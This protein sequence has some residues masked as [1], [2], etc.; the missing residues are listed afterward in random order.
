ME[1]IAGQSFRNFECILINNNSTDKSTIIAQEFVKT[2]PRFHLIHEKKQGVVFASNSGFKVSKGKYI[3]RMD[4]DD[5][6]FPGRLEK[7]FH[8]LE[9]NQDFDVVAGQVEHISH[10]KNSKGFERYVAWS[11]SI[12]SYQDLMNR[13]FIEMP[14]VNPATMWRKKTA[15]LLGMYQ[16]GNFPED[17]EMWLRWLDHGIK[18]KKLPEKVL[19]WYDSDSRLSRTH[20]NYSDKAFYNIKTLYLSKWLKA[21]NPFHPKVLIWGASK[22][23]RRRADLLHEYGINILGYIDITRKRKLKKKVFY[24]QDIPS[25]EEVFVLVYIKQMDA[26]DE[27]MAFLDSKGFIEGI[28]YLLV[29]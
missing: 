29:S 16:D 19:K 8:F 20:K 3:A 15:N 18:V 24:Y 2:D 7:Q 21:N 10:G 6:S 13:R 9:Q 12:L 25:K 28:N 11:N 23:S 27:I 5:W 14:F 17:Y 26:R 1:S 22:I 4:A